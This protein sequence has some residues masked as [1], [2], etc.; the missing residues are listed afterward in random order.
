MTRSSFNRNK[1]LIAG[2]T[3][4]VVILAVVVS[5]FFDDELKRSE[6]FSSGTMAA[7]KTATWRGEVRNPGANNWFEGG[8]WDGPI[9]DRTVRT[10][11]N[12]GSMGGKVDPEVPA[13]SGP[14]TAGTNELVIEAGGR[15][16]FASFPEPGV[17]V[18][19]GL[20]NMQNDGELLLGKGALVVRGDIL[21]DWGARFDG[22]Q[23]AVI[24]TG[25]MWDNRSSS[26]FFPGSGRTVLDGS[27]DQTIR[28][29]ISYYDLEILTADT[30][31]I[32][33]HVTVTNRLSV[34][35]KSIVVIHPDGSLNVTGSTRNE[36]ILLKSSATSMATPSSANLA[37]SAAL[38]VPQSLELRPN[39][40]NPFN[41][42]TVIEFSV[43]A[44]NSASLKVYD[45]QGREIRTLFD[46]TA[47]A[48]RSYR[49][50]FDATG[51]SSGTY[52][53]VLQSGE[54]RKVGKMA[55]Q[56]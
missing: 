46:E 5:L 42:T 26:M 11:I 47:D 43:P 24:F 2:G 31:L 32:E 8:N 55:F 18:V 3:V 45:I 19:H 25:K 40:P 27:S 7:A 17:L 52:L 41:P 56:K 10:V 23:G 48:G 14:D 35:P 36:G 50:T 16:T 28:G 9:P 34:G 15:V 53:Y 44:T 29:D 54:M 22:G 37:P 1:L 39:Y 51:L 6:Q 33:G 4:A 21:L 30:V 49:I 13:P 12:L 20:W 38:A